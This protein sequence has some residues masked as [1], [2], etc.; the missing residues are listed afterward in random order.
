MN[1]I[2]TNSCD[3]GCSYCFAAKTRKDDPNNSMT[4]DQ[5]KEL[6]DK[7]K[8]K[9]K[10]LGGEPTN[11]PQFKEIVEYLVNEKR[12]FF[13]IS[14]FLFDE[15]KLEIIMNAMDKV[16]VDFLINASDLDKLNRMETWKNNYSSVYMKLY[17]KD[18]EENMSI[19]ITIDKPLDYYIK[20][21][22]YLLEN[23]SVIERFRISLAF[24]DTKKDDFYFINNKELGT[25]ITSI[26][27]YLVLKGIKPSLDCVLF[28]CMFDNK[29]QF[30]YI[31]KFMENVRTKCGTNLPPS[32]VF[33]DNTMSY[34][35]PTKESLKVDTTKYKTLDEA[36]ADLLTRYKIL[37]SQVDM[38]EECKSCKFFGNLCD[39]P[40]LGFFDLKDKTTGINV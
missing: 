25:E 6:T 24:P 12:D 40:C 5:F 15:D 3:K 17:K 21:F 29:E 36:S 33:L 16:N 32:D 9:V 31:R 13:L 1:Y 27:N 7:S 37:K 35:Y 10:L 34:C 38:P 8:A 28:P 30:K 26:V 39:G 19:G 18:L 23:I 4:L 2:I 22:D 20:Y 11:H 14:N